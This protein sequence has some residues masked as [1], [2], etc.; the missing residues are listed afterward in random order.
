MC[1]QFPRPA[2]L[3]FF[4]VKPCCN[5]T[6]RK[7]KKFCVP[8]L[9]NDNDGWVQLCTLKASFLNGKLKFEFKFDVS[10]N[11]SILARLRLHIVPEIFSVLSFDSVH[12]LAPDVIACP[13]IRPF[14]AKLTWDQTIWALEALS[15]LSLIRTSQTEANSDETQSRPLLIRLS[16]PGPDQFQTIVRSKWPL[17]RPYLGQNYPR[18]DHFLHFMPP[19]T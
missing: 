2:I 9:A 4:A 14:E 5:L 16:D 17:I 6:G 7:F 19:R 11:I 10:V 12:T 13:L 8:L 1:K 3:D 18:S 15:N